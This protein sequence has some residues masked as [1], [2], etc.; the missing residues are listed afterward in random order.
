MQEGAVLAG[1]E[2]KVSNT[3]EIIEIVCEKS[4]N[5][6]SGRW[7]FLIVRTS[8]AGLSV[9]VF[10]LRLSGRGCAGSSARVIGGLI[11]SLGPAPDA[12]VAALG[13]GGPVGSPAGLGGAGLSVAGLPLRLSGRACA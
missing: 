9:A 11:A 3:K 1:G 8:G 7:Y 13:A 5:M 6:K 10:L 2:N 4:K 12:V